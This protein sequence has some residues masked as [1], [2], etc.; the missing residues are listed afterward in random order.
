MS[1]P[2]S[3][4]SVPAGAPRRWPLAWV[5]ELHFYCSLLMAAAFL[6]YGV[7]G[8]LADQGDL[9]FDLQDASAPGS[10]SGRLPADLP[11]QPAALTKFLRDGPGQGQRLGHVDPGSVE[12][13][14]DRLYF[15]LVSVWGL[16]AVEVAK[17]AR[18]FS[19]RSQRASWTKALVSLH[20]N[21]GAGP[22]QRWLAD[23]VALLLVVVTA[24]GIVLGAATP[25]RRRWIAVLL[26][27]GSMLL[28]AFLLVG[29]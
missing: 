15:D 1:E 21:R 3:E 14:E 25:G 24:T 16:H 5:R 23:G 22:A 13:R 7:T 12:D 18:T 26:L 28:L 2:T 20:S 19:V 8:F 4:A 29:R 11:L 9:P 17:G 10:W 6:F 27:A